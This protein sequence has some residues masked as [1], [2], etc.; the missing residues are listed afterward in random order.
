MRR[1][2]ITTEQLLASVL[3]PVFS[4]QDSLVN[5]GTLTNNGNM[6]MGGVHGL[7]SVHTIPE[8]AK[9]HLMD[10]PE[11]RK[12]LITIINRLINLLLA[13]EELSKSWLT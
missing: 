13:E 9:L 7:T 8:R 10:L 3:I 5:N 6:M 12:S 11:K 4:V 1:V 2:F